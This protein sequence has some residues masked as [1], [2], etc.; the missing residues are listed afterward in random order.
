MRAGRA[1]PALAPLLLVLRH[2]QNLGLAAQ[3]CVVH[4]TLAFP[5]FNSRPL[6]ILQSTTRT[7]VRSKMQ[8]VLYPSYQPARSPPSS[9]SAFTRKGP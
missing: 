5:Y 1:H 4:E 9:N 8:P 3:V 7:D 6:S 2:S